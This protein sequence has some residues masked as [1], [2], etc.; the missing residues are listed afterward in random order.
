M[1]LTKFNYSEF[2]GKPQAW[3]LNGL[4]LEKVNLLVGK[5]ATG[6]TNALT[7]IQWFGNMLAGL[8]PQ[9]LQSGSFDVEFSDNDKTYHYLL[10]VEKQVVLS[11]ELKIGDDSMFQRDDSGTGEIFAQ[12]FQ[13][14][15]RFKLPNNQLVVTSKRDVIQHPFLE[16]IANWADG[17]RLY[18]FSSKLGQDTMFSINDMND[19]NVNPR[20]MRSVIALYVKGEHDFGQ[21]FR[22][23][24]ITL[25]STIGYDL[26]NIG[27]ASNPVLAP[28]IPVGITTNKLPILMLY[29]GE[30][31]SKIAVFQQQMSQGMFRALS[32]IIQ[33]TY[34]SLKKLS[35]TVLIDDIGEG[36]DFDRSSKLIK[37]LIDSANTTDTQFIMSTNDR[38]V[39]NNVPLEY[40][41]VI[42]RTYGE[43]KIFNSKNSKEIFDDFEY[44]GLS[45]FDFLKTDFI[46][47]KW[48][49]A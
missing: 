7:K 1:L 10:N 29:V 3:S 46:N 11:E 6:K 14:K 8:Q 27:V 41:Q 18:D 36:L 40:W 48:E 42:Q 30:K 25:M 26:T 34:N 22:K 12:E 49:T 5:N 43:C 44:T 24:I 28:P 4:A 13:K 37:L 16:N 23:Q 17:Q 31:N 19:I 15:M 35:T 45:N 32:L 21:D 38:F 20:D 39:M 2:A 47:S 33:I 9:L